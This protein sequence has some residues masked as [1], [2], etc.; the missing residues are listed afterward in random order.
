LIPSSGSSREQ[1][2]ASPIPTLHSVRG[3][4]AI[5]GQD[6]AALVWVK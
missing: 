6:K 2:L 1:P 5:P 3:G 4:S